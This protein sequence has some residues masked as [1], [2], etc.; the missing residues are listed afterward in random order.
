MGISAVDTF[1]CCSQSLPW[2]DFSK[3][4]L[5]NKSAV[6]AFQAASYLTDPLSKCHEFYRR[7]YVVEACYPEAYAISNLARKIVLCVGAVGWASLAV[8]TTLPGVA[9]RYL[10]SYLQTKP[11]IYVQ[12]SA[13]DKVMLKDY[14]LSLL[15]WNICGI[16]GGY[17]I[18]DGG[19]LPWAFRIDEIINKLIEK[20]ADVNCL[21][22]VFDP[23]SAFYI[24]EKLKEHGYS[25]FYFNIGPR[26]IGVSSGI[27]VASKYNI[28]NPEFSPFPQDSLIGRTKNVAKGVF[29]FDLESED[30]NFARI[31]ATHLQHSEEPQFPTEEEV[32]ARK[33]QMQIIVDKMNSVR[34]RCIVVTGDLNLDDDEYQAS[35]WNKHFQKGNV[36]SASDKTWDGDEFCARMVGKRI[37][38]SLN[39]DHTMVVKGTARAISTSLV[40]TGYNPAIFKA[41]ALSDHGGLLSRIYTQTT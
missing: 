14:S 28:K 3:D 22:E 15:S 21:Y 2:C 35:S 12:G 36:F 20:N 23:N 8:F 33:W 29:A 17:S 27:L 39:L 11:F 32:E 10:G 34:D 25:H 5:A 40:S 6:R 18:S 24:C 41:G 4:A 26:A 31:Y 37:S 9:L 30:K 13:N 19:V 16:E 1:N 38:G 7:I